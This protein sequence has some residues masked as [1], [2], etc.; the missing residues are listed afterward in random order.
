M[1]GP[2]R[3]DPLVWGAISAIGFSV[4]TVVYALGGYVPPIAETGHFIGG[5]F[6][7]GMLAAWVRNLPMG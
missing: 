6:F 5:A 4:A 1:A 7:F 3:A 2:K